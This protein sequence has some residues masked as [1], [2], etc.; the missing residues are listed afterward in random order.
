M[1]VTPVEVHSS[2]D[3]DVWELIGG[4]APKWRMGI[5]PKRDC[6]RRATSFFPESANRGLTSIGVKSA[7]SGKAGGLNS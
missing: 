3:R 4:T 5:I 1:S 6:P 7:T 2:V